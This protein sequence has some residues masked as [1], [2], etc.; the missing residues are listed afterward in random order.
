MFTFVVDA[1]EVDTPQSGINTDVTTNS[2]NMEELFGTPYIW[3]FHID[4]IFDR[5]WQCQL[6]F[7]QEKISTEGGQ[8][9]AFC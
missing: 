3:C 9:F 7:L 8:Q 2:N 5:D 1:I 6:K 4:Q